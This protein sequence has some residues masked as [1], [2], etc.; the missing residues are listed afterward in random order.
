MR[1]IEPTGRDTNRAAEMNPDRLLQLG[2]AFWGAKT[3]LSAVELGVFTELAKG[4]LGLERISE[5]L[6]L[7]PRGA[8]DF[9]DALVALGVLERNGEA[10]NNAADA[11]LFLDRAKP[12]Y[13]GGLFEMA[14][15]RLYP[16]WVSLT[17]TR[18]GIAAPGCRK[19]GS[20]KPGR[21]TWSDRNRWSSA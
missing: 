11:D 21:S 1:G 20:S 8:R 15:A 17:D 6:G 5:R 13:I 9:L 3:L 14:N 19:P 4:P 2:L 7:H 10:H 18:R 12:S 16:F